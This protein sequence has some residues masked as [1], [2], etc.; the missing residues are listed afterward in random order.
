MSDKNKVR[1]ALA[2]YAHDAWSGWMRYLFSKCDNAPAGL[3]ELGGTVPQVI[4]AWAVERWTRQ[5]TTRYD[6]LPEDEKVSDRKEADKMLSILRSDVEQAM[7]TLLHIDADWT[8]RHEA[9]EKLAHLIGHPW[10][11]YDVLHPNGHC[12]CGGEGTCGWCERTDASLEREPE[13]A[14]GLRPGTGD[15]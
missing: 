10:P 15:S 13:P 3:V 6:G 2:A 14:A 1:E 7:H 4:P 5:L 12:T 11:P 8:E 9:A